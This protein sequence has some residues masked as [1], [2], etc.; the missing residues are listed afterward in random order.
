MRARFLVVPVA[1]ALSVSPA[2]AQSSSEKV[3]ASASR[4]QSP[5]QRLSEDE[6]AIRRIIVESI[7]RFNRRHLG[8]QATDY[9]ADADFVNVYGTWRKGAAEIQSGQQ[10]RMET[11]LKDAKITLLDLKIRFV[12]PDVAI[13][14]QSHRMS[15][16]RDPAGNIMPPHVERPMR[17]LV[18]DEGGWRITAFHN[19]IVR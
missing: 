3:Q 6:E 9:T 4:E 19:T 10:Q 13:A 1:I 12:R 2:F 17:V 5:T 16:M 7:D 11:V 14:I 18:K 8:P 15:G